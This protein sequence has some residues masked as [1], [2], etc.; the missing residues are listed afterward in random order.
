[1]V[2]QILLIHAT[3]E[4]IK[5]DITDAIDCNKWFD[6][7]TQPIM[8]MRVEGRHLTFHRLNKSAMEL[9]KCGVDD[10][11]KI[12]PISIGLFSSEY[13]VHKYIDGAIPAEGVSY[14][15]H[16]K[17]LIEPNIASEITLFKS[18]GADG[19]TYITAFQQNAGNT[20]K[21]LEALRRTEYRFLLMAESITDGLMIFENSK[22][23]FV[24]SAVSHITGYTKEQIADINEFHLACDFEKERVSQFVGE[25]QMARQKVYNIEFWIKTRMGGE[26]CIKCVY[27]SSRAIDNVSKY[28]IIT[29]VTS[30]KLAEQALIKTQSEFKM[31]ADNSPDMITRYTRSL[32]YSYVNKTVETIT[33]IPVESF[34]GRNTLDIEID[35]DAASFIEEMHLEVFRTGRKLKFEFR[36][37]TNVGQRVFQASM[38]PEFAKDGSVSTVLNVSRDITQIKEAERKLY[39]E[40]QRII[41]NNKQIAANIKL[42]GV[43]LLET[44]PHLKKTS[45]MIALNRIAE[46]AS[47]D[48]CLTKYE[49]TSVEVDSYLN[50]YYQR[51]KAELADLNIDIVLTTPIEK[52]KIFTDV[53]ILTIIFDNLV[54]NAVEAKGVSRIEIGFGVDENSEVVF[55]VKDNGAGFSSDTK[56]KIFEPFYVVDKDGHSGLGLSAVKRC[57]EHLKGRI[58]CYSSENEGAQFFFTH[59][60]S[61]SAT[62]SKPTENNNKWAS[63]KIHVV[64]DTDANYILIE[65]MLKINGAPELTRSV[66]GAEAIE[67]VRN[68]PE[69]D[70]VL[71]DIQMPDINGYEATK[72]IRTFNTEVPIIAQTAYAMYADVVKA[73]DSGCNDFIAKPIKIK[74]MITL[75]EKY[76]G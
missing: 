21:V 5:F 53:N 72:M 3:M 58:W 55:F 35:H 6:N 39:E 46:W 68:H 41:E 26:K 74:K 75:L 47:L 14:I 23:I 7:S 49:P 67:Y 28:I 36:F 24:N 13:D 54:D 63:K 66:N 4:E 18:V 17:P 9:L 16:I 70:L 56:P 8:V 76:L 38:V 30:Q 42:L 48:G 1:M 50:G 12:N 32:T 33:K 27:T 57:V 20:I 31:L 15:V 65:A 62:I 64:E 25:M 22:L 60:I 37:N 40:K 71:M 52:I 61:S 11:K 43:K 51:R 44:A 29:D 19:S 34:I 59:A 45:A 73:L 2:S 10:I 69:I